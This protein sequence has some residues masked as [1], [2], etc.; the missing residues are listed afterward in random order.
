MPHPEGSRSCEAHPTGP[1]ADLHRGAN[2]GRASSTDS[3]TDPSRDV[4]MQVPA[5]QVVQKTIRDPQAHFNNT[6][7]D[8][9]VVQS[10]NKVVDVLVAVQHQA[11]MVQEV[12]IQ[13][14]NGECAV[15]KD[16]NL[17]CKFHCD[18]TSRA[19]RG[20]SQI[21]VTSGIDADDGLN[22]PTHTKFTGRSNQITIASP[23]E[24]DHV[25]QEAENHRDENEVN[26]TKIEDENGPENHCVPM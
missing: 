10:M 12:Q 1:G 15:T 3:T 23:T 14:F 24:N 5:V 8:I 25:A 17:Q 2:C 6:V 13:V 18:G 22:V 26:N 16:N 7:T 11:P 19:P 4:Q 21:E 20:A 9:P